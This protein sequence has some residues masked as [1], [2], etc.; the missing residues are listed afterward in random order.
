MNGVINENKV[1]IVKEYEFDKLFIQKMDSVF[2]TCIRD[3]HNECF[4]TFEYKSVCD[5]QLKTLVI[6]E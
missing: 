1:T 6:M 2:D 4:Q 3:C 5:F